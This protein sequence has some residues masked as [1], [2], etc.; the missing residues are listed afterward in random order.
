ME[1][2]FK[3]VGFRSFVIKTIILIGLIIF[4]DL[5]IAVI[6]KNT[7][8][9]KK[10]L[11]IPKLFILPISNLKTT[12]LNSALFG[13]VVFCIIS[14]KK[15]LDIKKFEFRT[16]QTALIL[17]AVIVLFFQYFYRF[18]I[19]KNL[20]FFSRN[21]MLWAIIKILITIIYMLILIVGIYGID[22]VKYILKDYK[23]EIVICLSVSISFF[24]LMILVQN[25]WTYFSSFIS[26]ILYH[27]FSVFFNNV[28]YQ[29]YVTSFTMSEGGGPLLGINSF[30]AII[31]KPCSGIDSF[32]LFTC[33]YA[34][35]YVLEYKRIRKGLA[36]ILFFVGALGMFL[37]NIL[38]IFLLFIIGA[39]WNPEFA[40]GMFHSNVGWILFLV[41]FFIFWTIVSKTIYKTKVIKK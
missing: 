28:T 14:Y 23:K 9:F 5:L 16:N 3:R 41:Y 36:I 27:I 8:F 20:D 11:D 17:L 39:F 12:L 18:L 40:I 37:T 6:F 10:Y 15:I 25:L 7:V 35:I 32:L 21:Y 38:R 33:L 24:F 2:P 31:G 22:F 26:N 29:P 19:N 13:V 30:K 34:I 1:N 4:I